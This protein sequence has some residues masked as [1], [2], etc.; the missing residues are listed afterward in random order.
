M[1]YECHMNNLPLGDVQKVKQKKISK[2]TTNEPDSK[3]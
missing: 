2:I 1:V 3:C